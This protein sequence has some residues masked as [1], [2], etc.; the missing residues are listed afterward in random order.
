MS[1][2]F[3][4][5]DLFVETPEIDNVLA[6]LTKFD[7]LEALYEVTGDFDIVTIFSA[8]SLEEFKS[9]LKNQILKIKGV[10]SAVTSTCSVSGENPIKSS[11]FSEKL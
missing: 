11:I 6:A 3:G 9:F 5:I 10:K 1:R 2:M 8:A 7:N 4:L